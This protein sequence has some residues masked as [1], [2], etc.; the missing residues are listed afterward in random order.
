MP[1]EYKN[2]QTDHNNNNNIKIGKPNKV[3]LNKERIFFFVCFLCS[4]TGN[5]KKQQH[6]IE[7]FFLRGFN[8]D[9]KKTKKIFVLK[10]QMKNLKFPKKNLVFNINFK[11]N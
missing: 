7:Q 3:H 6:N 10:F 11:P 1:Q 8:Q 2:V 5:K 9:M 4:F